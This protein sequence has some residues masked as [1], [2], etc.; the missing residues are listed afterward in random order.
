[1][2]GD[3]QLTSLRCMARWRGL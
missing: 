3:H 2:P 1:V